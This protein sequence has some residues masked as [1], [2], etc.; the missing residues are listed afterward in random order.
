MFL[1]SKNLYSSLKS[2]L[3]SP[4]FS[5]FISNGKTFLH[6]PNISIS[7]ASISISPV[8]ILL[9]LLAL[10]ITVPVTPIALSVTISFKSISA[11]TTTCVIPSSSLKS[12][13]FIAPRF[14]IVCTQPASFTVFPTSLI[15]N[16]P[17][18]LVLYLL[19]FFPPFRKSF[20]H[21]KSPC[22]H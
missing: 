2:S 22:I 19:I 17:Q 21:T 4:V 5:E 13:N 7:F 20:F 15:L 18:L 9:F 14:L 6:L 3:A 1:K 11:D 12:I 8:G 10:S 16:S